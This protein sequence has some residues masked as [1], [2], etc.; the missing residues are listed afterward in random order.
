MVGF[1]LGLG[2]SDWQKPWLFEARADELADD[3]NAVAEELVHLVLAEPERDA[4]MQSE[5]SLVAVGGQ[6]SRRGL[7]DAG[8]DQ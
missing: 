7:A 5:G 2:I 1:E 6:A 4:A 3:G 8:L